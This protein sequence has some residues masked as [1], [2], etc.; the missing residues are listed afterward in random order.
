MSKKSQKDHLRC[1]RWQYHYAKDKQTKSRILDSFC[2]LRGLE[3]KYAIKL[4]GGS[5]GVPSGEAK[6]R[7]RGGSLARYGPTEIAVL[8]TVWL[9]SEQPCGKR[10]KALLPLWVPSWERRNGELEAGCRQRLLSLSASH[11]DRL[12]A[13]YKIGDGV[14]RP[15][16]V[17]EVRSQIP[18]RTGPWQVGGPGWLE[19]D[20]V[21]HCGTSMAGGF[22]WSLVLTDIWSGWTE[23]RVTWN[24]SD[25]VT[26]RRLEQI[27]GALPFDV[28][29]FD[30][31]N[32]GEF[33]NGTVLRYYRQRQRPVEV[34]RS[35]PYHKNDN[36]HVEQKN[37]THVREFLGHERID[38]QELVELLNAVVEMWSLWNNLFCPTLKLLEK[39]RVGTRLK[40][41]YEKHPRTPCQRLLESPALS[42]T[43]KERL[44]EQ[45][46]R[47]DPW[48]MK[49][50]I[51]QDLRTFWSLHARA[52]PSV[53][54]S[55]V[56]APAELAKPQSQ[57]AS[58]RGQSRKP[59]DRCP[60]TS[61]P[62]A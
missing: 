35:R 51:E 59:A 42:A 32:G 28:V 43:R 33:I 7:G 45:L 48:D 14:R 52:I 54:M 13:C 53:Q 30:S 47:H 29:G 11:M 57:V 22:V 55:L 4:L 62:T 10:L 17:N 31:D 5:R 15:H 56:V 61:Q 16:R 25:Y 20:T 39:V 12:L 36:A 24:R 6:S 23:V 49:I 8:K 19:G 18:L 58:P 9:L 3:R 44:R 27:E 38:R 21:A 41:V 2:A 26:H 50:R 60:L 40:K 37:R 1:A 46:A 34:T